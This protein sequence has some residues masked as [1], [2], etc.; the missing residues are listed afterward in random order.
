MIYI[1]LKIYTLLYIYA[2]FVQCTH[3]LPSQR[4]ANTRYKDFHWPS[5]LAAQK[6]PW[7]SS[8]LLPTS[9]ASPLSTLRLTS[10]PAQCYTVSSLLVF[11]Q[12]HAFP[13][14]KPGCLL[15]I[16]G[17]DPDVPSCRR[18]PLKHLLTPE[19]DVTSLLLAAC[20]PICAPHYLM[21]SIRETATLSVPKQEHCQR[22]VFNKYCTDYIQR[23]LVLFS[24][25]SF[26]PK[27]FPAH[28]PET[29]VYHLIEFWLPQK[30]NQQQWG[31]PARF[32]I[33][34]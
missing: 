20:G 5:P 24:C 19:L 10:E 16:R 2:L 33:W 14:S 9:L 11:C 17:F 18:D 30:G 8:T 1:Q 25:T 4:R 28:G 3:T 22:Q 21:G 6:G 26:P 23:W 31:L 12:G 32:W 27:E 13:S 15:L 29:F 34:H 7:W